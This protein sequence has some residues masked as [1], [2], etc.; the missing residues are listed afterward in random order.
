MADAVRYPLE[1]TAC[2]PRWRSAGRWQCFTTPPSTGARWRTRPA[3][4]S[5][6]GPPGFRGDARQ[7]AG[8]ADHGDRGPPGHRSATGPHGGAVR[9]SGL[10]GRRGPGARGHPQCHLHAALPAAGGARRH[11]LPARQGLRAR[12]ERWPKRRP[13]RD[14]LTPMARPLRSVELLASGRVNALNDWLVELKTLLPD[15]AAYAMT[16]GLRD[17]RDW[18]ATCRPPRTGAARSKRCTSRDICAGAGHRRE[19][20]DG[21]AEPVRLPGRG[22]ADRLALPVGDS[23]PCSRPSGS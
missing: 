1:R 21:H 23:L 13:S 11:R 16:S 14:S 6:R 3:R 2:V 22:P 4:R 17:W 9:R 19:G 18:V 8:R 15:H 20:G 10:A 12:D 7:M 5:C